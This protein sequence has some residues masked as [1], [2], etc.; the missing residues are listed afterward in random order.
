MQD[1]QRKRLELMASSSIV[2]GDI[3]ALLAERDALAAALRWAMRIV[4]EPTNRTSTNGRYC[5]EYAAAKS[6]LA[7]ASGQGEG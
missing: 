4:P 6:V 5:D 2:G 7:A 1:D 3:R